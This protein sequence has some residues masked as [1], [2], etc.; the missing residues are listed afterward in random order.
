MNDEQA[1]VLADFILKKHP[2]RLE[3]KAFK[4]G[5]AHRDAE[6]WTPVSEGLPEEFQDC[7]VTLANGLVFRAAYAAI[8]N[9][10]SLP[11][12]GSTVTND[13]VIAWRLLPKPYQEAK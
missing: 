10:W 7:L 8:L 12:F 3:I 6:G 5:L 13:G 9:G 2:T 11:G 1:M 4:L